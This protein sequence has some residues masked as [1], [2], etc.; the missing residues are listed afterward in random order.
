MGDGDIPQR[1][2]PYAVE[3][4]LGRGGMGTVYRARAPGGASVALK[5]IR[6]ALLRDDTKRR[7]E[8]EARIRIEHDN[9]VKVLDAGEDTDGTAYIALELLDGMTLAERLVPGP[10]SEEGVIDVAVQVCRGLEAAHE[11]GIVHRDLKPSNIFCCRDGT[12]KLLDFG[13]AT[14]Q[15]AETRLTETGHVLGTICY[16]APE[17]LEGRDSRDPR[18]DVWSLGAVLFEALAGRPPFREETAL[19]TVVSTMLGELPSLSSLRPGVSPALE[20]VIVRALRKSSA[21]RWASV[22]DFRIALE[23]VAQA[24]S[25]VFTKTVVSIPPDEQRVVALLYAIDVTDR[26][27]LDRAIRREHGIP[28]GA[29]RDRII[30]LFGAES[31]VGDEITRA[32]RAAI[33]SHSAAKKIVVSSGRASSTRMAIAGSAIDEAERLLSNERMGVAMTSG[34]ARG[35]T[36]SVM[37]SPIGGDAFELATGEH[38]LAA[39]SEPSG[40]AEIIG[41]EIELLQIQRAISSTIDERACASMWITGPPGIGKS[42]L[43]HEAERM[44]DDWSP[45]FTRLSARAEPAHARQ[46]LS[47]FRALLRAHAERLGVASAEAPHALAECAFTSSEDIARCAD[48]FRLLLLSGQETSEDI[49]AISASDLQSIGDRIQLALLDW[50]LALSSKSP[51]ALVL[52]DLHW[53]S[54]T[55]LALLERIRAHAFEQ[56]LLIVATARLELTEMRPELFADVNATRLELRGLGIEQVRLLVERILGTDMNREW[57]ETLTKRTEGNPFFVEQIV[58]GLDEAPLDLDTQRLPWSVEAALQARLDHLTPAE[59]DLC[60]KAAVLG[61][62]FTA[63]ELVALGV[64]DPRPVL[65]ALRRRGIFAMRGDER[66]A[67]KSPLL[68][69]AAYNMVTDDAR[70]GLHARAAEVLSSMQGSDAE[71]VAQ[72]FERGGAIEEASDAYLRALSVAAMRGDA[73]TMLRTSDRALHLGIRADKRFDVRMARADALRFVGQRDAQWAELEEA[74]ELAHTDAQRARVLSE[75]CVAASRRGSAEAP[76]LGEAAVRAARAS[77]DEVATTLAL[78]RLLLSLLQLGRPRE[79]RT[80]LDE[81][82]LLSAT[83]D[84]RIRALVSEWE[85]QYAGA[86]GDLEA[87]RMAFAQAA[88]LHRETG[89]LRRA[90]GAETNLADIDNRVG[91]YEAAARALTEARDACRKVGHHVMEGYALANLAYSQTRMGMHEEALEVLDAA[92][93]IAERLG[94]VRLACAVRVYRAGALLGARRA[95]ESAA[96]AARAAKDASERG[97]PNLEIAALT[98]E[99]EALLEMGDARMAFEKSRRAIEQM[100]DIGAVE[101]DEISVHL[102]HARAAE[103]IGEHVLADDIKHNARMRLEELANAI[104]DPSLRAAFLSNVPAHRELQDSVCTASKK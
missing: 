32:A 74:F 87:R 78:G 35:L 4:V 88:K 1:V 96:L 103:A 79:A 71:E 44:I 27:A 31:T 54:D 53:A 7:F 93:E 81:A 25:R 12:I 102:A 72:H 69:E 66:C 75:Q 97:M 17:Q 67:F 20:S 58:R 101:E 104:L 14:L 36:A 30:G 68:S 48:M 45:R 57:I 91:A 95:D 52:E 73:A 89:D 15:H 76:L 28:I 63:A 37:L 82:V 39:L 90:A 8:R 50:V 80:L 86:T 47:L 56:P 33:R 100:R 83:C 43:R 11:V 94:E 5:V 84:A 65:M 99:A 40:E 22:R 2:G 26:V 42:R 34:A 18:S 29:L 59:R 6:A 19:A 24:S 21:A 16:L 55:S 23:D 13:V 85:G 61:R 64:R 98:L 46:E 60:C 10:L 62:S 9:V 49:R 51:L 38:A 41:R 92:D 70:A 3:G 77:G